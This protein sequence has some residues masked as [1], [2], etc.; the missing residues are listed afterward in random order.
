MSEFTRTISADDLARL[1]ADRE[2]ADARYNAALTALDQ[3]VQRLPSLP[4]PPPGPD[5][6]QITP[7]NQAWDLQA[8]GPP[9]AAGWRGLLARLVWPVMAPVVAAQQRFNSALV[10]HVNR[11][12]PRERA[13]PQAIDATIRLVRT[14]IDESIRFQS[15]V[16]VYLQAITPFVDTK[17]YEFAGL[18]RR[19]TEDVATTAATLD[20]VTRGFAGG[21]SALSDEVVKRY[22]SLTILTQRQAQALDRSAHRR[23]RRTA[24]DERPAAPARARRERLARARRATAAGASPD[25]HCWSSGRAA[26]DARPRSPAQPSVRGIRRRLPRRRGRHPR[27]HAR[28]RRPLRGRQRRARRRL[29]PGGVPRAAARPRHHR[30]GH[31]PQRRD[32]RALPG[33]GP[34]RHR[35]RRA[36]LPGRPRRRVVGRPDRDAGGRA[37]AARRAD[38]VSRV[39]GP[40]A[41]RPARP[42]CSRPSTRRA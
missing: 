12:L 15:H 5:E 28:L 37:P 6:H 4:H 19:A 25:G 33:Q 34:R 2:A 42:S 22:D 21:L 35:R 27:A 18:A 36:R 41:P 20:D 16:I 7:L 13:V 17:D 10:D 9:P 29:W 11:N 31:R 23:G 8:A 40:Q 3:A 30:P 39:G 38:A 26:A 1:K 32:G 24:D 14:H